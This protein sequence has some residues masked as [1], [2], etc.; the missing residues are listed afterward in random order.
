M[1]TELHVLFR[2]MDASDA[3]RTSVEK[4]VAK[5]EELAQDIVACKV[6]VELEQKHQ[7]QGRPFGVR[8][9][10]TLRGHEIAINKVHNE[11]VYVALRDAFQ[12]AKRQLQR[13]VEERRGQVKQHI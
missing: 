9:D 13:L 10:L 2:G 6:Y 4:F 7:H 11:D 3:V 8:I 5:L 1:K 12:A